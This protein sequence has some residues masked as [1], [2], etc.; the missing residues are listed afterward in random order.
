[1]GNVIALATEADGYQA[2]RCEVCGG[3]MGYNQPINFHEALVLVRDFK[4]LHEGCIPPNGERV[5]LN[6]DHITKTKGGKKVKELFYIAATKLKP[7]PGII[8]LAWRHGAY[9][10]A[11]WNEDTG[12]SIYGDAYDIEL[13]KGKEASND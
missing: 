3:K 10:D 13:P 1:M 4:E 8:G 6:L 5:C 11:I 12:K 2:W 7:K 9:R